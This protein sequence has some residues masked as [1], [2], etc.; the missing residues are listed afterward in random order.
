MTAVAGAVPT[1]SVGACPPITSIQEIF[2]LPAR[3]PNSL[4][5]SSIA[6]TDYLFILEMAKREIASEA[7]PES[8]PV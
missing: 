8:D 2:D 1:D 3:I 5:F 7:A 6:F 4:D